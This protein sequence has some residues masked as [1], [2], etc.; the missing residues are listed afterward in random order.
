MKITAHFL[1]VVL[2]TV[3]TQVGGV[4]YLLSLLVARFIRKQWRFKQFSLF[5]TSYGLATFLIVPP[6]A[7]FFGREPVSHAANIAPT[8]YLTV[9][10]NRNY[11]KP[12]MN[13]VLLSTAKS[14]EAT[15]IELRYLDA[16]FPFINGFPLLPHL[17]HNDGE[18][19]DLSFVYET[20]EQKI[21]TQQK[22]R[23]GYGAF[24]EPTAD[25]FNQIE[26]CVKSGYWQYGFTQYFTLGRINQHLIFS[27]SGTRLVVEKL[28]EQRAVSK[29][30]IEPHLKTRLGL[31]SNRVRYHGCRAVRHDD[32]IHVQ[33]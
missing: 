3:L 24:T 5:V 31:T 30:F 10:F 15:D 19:I 9:V 7:S 18:K 25:E 17:S 33:L 2:L 22:S 13:T 21:T 14:L 20:Q 32:H 8:N 12:A 26:K 16:S 29:I 28:L 27:N 23:S 11:V 6:L 1:L 4:I